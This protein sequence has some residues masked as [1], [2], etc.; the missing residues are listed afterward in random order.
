MTSCCDGEVEGSHG[1]C[2]DNNYLYLLV[3]LPLITLVILILVLIYSIC[4]MKAKLRVLREHRTNNKLNLN[5]EKHDETQQTQTVNNP[6]YF[7]ENSG[8]SRMSENI[9]NKDPDLKIELQQKGDYYTISHM[10]FSIKYN[11]EVAVQVGKEAVSDVEE[12][13]HLDH[14]RGIND[15]SDNYL[16]VYS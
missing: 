5:Y 14:Q 10:M 12:Y 13:D 1:G 16:S 4:I 11:S 2:Q 9:L 8:F 3:I 6:I 7:Y 15:V